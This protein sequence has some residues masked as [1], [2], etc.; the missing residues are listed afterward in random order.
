VNG[1]RPEV[2]K[3]SLRVERKLKTEKMGAE[4]SILSPRNTKMMSDATVLSQYCQI[5]ASTTFSK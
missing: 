4:N 1:Q 3:E 5:A 2:L